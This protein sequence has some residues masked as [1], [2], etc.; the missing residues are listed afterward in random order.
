MDD[1]DAVGA[2]HSELGHVCIHADQIKPAWNALY[3]DAMSAISTRGRR[4][5]ADLIS[6]LRA[7]QVDLSRL[8]HDSPAAVYTSILEWTMSRTE[9]FEILGMPTP[10][11]TDQAWLPLRAL[12]RDRYVETES[13]VEEALAAYHATGEGSQGKRD[14]EIDARTIGTFR[15]LCVVIGGPG[16]GKSLLLKVL[17]REFSKDSFVSL[18]VRLRDLAKRME[19]DGCTVE[20]GIFRLG[21]DGSGIS[22]EQLR[23]ASFSK[24]VL[25]CDGLDECGNRQPTIVSGP[26]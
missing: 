22:P 24:L 17:A 1:G 14:G 20:E 3:R 4:T 19:R 13:S 9:H 7:S 11:S 8:S 21:L 15:K 23:A 18:H 26:A 6:V 25:L 10:L 12:V 2:A 5:F 16:S